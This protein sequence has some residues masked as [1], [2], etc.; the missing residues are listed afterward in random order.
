MS[1]TLVGAVLFLLKRHVGG[2]YEKQALAL[3]E[4]IKAELK[5]PPI[6]DITGTCNVTG[7]PSSFGV[8]HASAAHT[9][10]P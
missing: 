1:E 4:D 9:P 10:A 7:E 6:P 8:E 2:P 5:R 3:I